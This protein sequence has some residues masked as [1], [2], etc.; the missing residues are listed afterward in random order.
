VCNFSEI[1]RPRTRFADFFE[2]AAPKSNKKVVSM[3]CR[4]CDVA[5][6]S[7]FLRV[8][9]FGARVCFVVGLLPSFFVFFLFDCFFFIDESP[10]V[11]FLFL[12]FSCLSEVF[13]FFYFP[14]YFFSISRTTT[15]NRSNNS[16]TIT[17]TR[18]AQRH[19]FFPLQRTTTDKC[20][21]IFL[22]PHKCSAKLISR[23]KWKTVF[24]VDLQ[25]QQNIGV[26]T[27]I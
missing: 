18:T 24:V 11:F 10:D 15:N 4:V 20:N 17:R 25:H 22:L 8:A 12:V 1:F 3:R 14:L 2:A 21:N 23:K 27:F 16:S 5:S 6:A 9:A 7:V 19:P 13:W 26:V